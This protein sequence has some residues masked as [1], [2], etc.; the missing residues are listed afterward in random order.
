MVAGCVSEC[1]RN[2]ATP[3]SIGPT[4]SAPE[5]M[6]EGVNSDGATRFIQDALVFAVLCPCPGQ[7]TGW[8][9]SS[10]PRGF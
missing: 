8:P 3:S 4:S 5:R 6:T 1:I 7:E 2:P 10:L 9:C